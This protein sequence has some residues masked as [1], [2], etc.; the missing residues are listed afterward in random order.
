MLNNIPLEAAY[1]GMLRREYRGRRFY[2]LGLLA[3]LLA[4]VLFLLAGEVLTEAFAGCLG[5]LGIMLFPV[6]LMLLAYSS[7]NHGI[8]VLLFDQ[9]LVYIKAR[10]PIVL[11]WDQV[12]SVRLDVIR[13]YFNLLYIGNN[14][15]CAI[16]LKDGSS[17]ILDDRIDGIRNL[18]ET[19]A[20]A[21][22]DTT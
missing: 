22:K 7:S 11:A 21:V 5:F 17:M 1:L 14:Y 12:Q 2:K 18:S 3:L 13:N 20:E 4:P 6:G 15:R 8:R 10:K 19:I 9:G 16:L